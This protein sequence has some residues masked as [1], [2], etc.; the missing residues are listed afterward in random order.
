MDYIEG[1]TLFDCLSKGISIESQYIEEIDRVL[2]MAEHRGLNPSDIHL[3]NILLTKDKEI[4]LID[5]ARF[6][7]RKSC[8]QWDDLKTA[9]FKAYR[10]RFFPK[11]LPVRLMNAIVAIYKKQMTILK[12]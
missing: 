1:I 6:R 4:K 3:R 5:V 2:S 11:K 8:R 10:R 12:S 7:Q 9:Y